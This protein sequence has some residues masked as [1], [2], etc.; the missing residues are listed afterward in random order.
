[1]K[2]YNTMELNKIE[3]YNI[4]TSLEDET[5]QK[6]NFFNG[7]EF[8]DNFFKL[9]DILND[10]SNNSDEDLEILEG[11]E[12]FNKDNNIKTFK[13]IVIGYNKTFYNKLKKIENI[14]INLIKENKKNIG[15]EI[16]LK[17]E[18]SEK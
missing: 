12:Y 18:I 11:Y 4:L 3:L 17:E 13:R 14:K 9:F 8:K 2:G 5:L 1:M 7:L 15:I 6:E 10:I 16:I